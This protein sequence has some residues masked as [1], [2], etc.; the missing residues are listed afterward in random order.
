MPK[1]P[2]GIPYRAA[3]LLFVTVAVTLAASASD[4]LAQ[5]CAMCRT[6]LEGQSDPLTE[7]FNVSSLFLMATPYTVVATVGAWIVLAG[8][9]R[10]RQPA[11]DESAQVPLR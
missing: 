8:R 11:E 5:G 9:R 3:A 4:A 6:A 10:G 1:K 2:R 7:A